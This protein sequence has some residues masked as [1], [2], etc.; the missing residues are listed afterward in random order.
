MNRNI[1][2]R[3]GRLGY[4]I[5]A[6]LTAIALCIG[7]YVIAGLFDDPPAEGFAEIQPAN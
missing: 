3:E 6:I 2:H 7:T 5:V 1:I 4:E